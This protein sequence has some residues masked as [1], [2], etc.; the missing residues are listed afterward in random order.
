MPEVK[1]KEQATST[2]RDL[3]LG[4]K[5][6]RKAFALSMGEATRK[7]YLKALQEYADYL[8]AHR[9][10]LAAQRLHDWEKTK[11]LWDRHGKVV[12]VLGAGAL[13][14]AAVGVGSAAAAAGGF[15]TLGSM[16]GTI[17]GNWLLLN[18]G[19]VAL[20]AAFGIGINV[21]TQKIWNYT[22]NRM[23]ASKITEM[24]KVEAIV[25]SSGAGFGAFQRS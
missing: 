23:Y 7:V 8:F 10:A 15:L 11:I 3:K 9:G 16:V 19:N 13:L 22:F 21:G 6:A 25:R 1:S 4:L 14:A 2:E 17:A 20:G 5:H 18:G 12:K 24:E